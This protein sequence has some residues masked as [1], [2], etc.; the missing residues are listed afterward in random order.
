MENGAMFG[1]L[2]RFADP[3]Y[4]QG[5][6]SG[7]IRTADDGYGHAYTYTV[8][9]DPVKGYFPRYKGYDVYNTKLPPG[10]E[11]EDYDGFVDLLE[12]RLGAMTEQELEDLMSLFGYKAPHT[13]L[14]P[15]GDDLPL[16]PIAFA[17]AG[18][19]ALAAAVVLGL[20]RRV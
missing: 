20:K 15:T 17:A 13:G 10:T 12:S 16:W 19:L 1:G 6:T 18:L 2:D 4:L 3:A 7:R 11:K 5:H 9:E 8:R 14:L